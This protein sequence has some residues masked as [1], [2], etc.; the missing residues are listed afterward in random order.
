MPNL[1]GV[2]EEKE[3][4]SIMKVV[5]DQIPVTHSPSMQHITLRLD[6]GESLAIVDDRGVP[7]LTLTQEEECESMLVV[8]TPGGRWEVKG[9]FKVLYNA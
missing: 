1:P 4:E 3:E 5:T 9:G 7:R 6:R 8:Q 2:R